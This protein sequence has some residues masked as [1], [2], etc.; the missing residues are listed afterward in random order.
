M[1]VRT[2]R[3]ATLSCPSDGVKS[4]L[5]P[6]LLQIWLAEATMAGFWSHEM[7]FGMAPKPCKMSRAAPV[8]EMICDADLFLIRMTI[9]MCTKRQVRR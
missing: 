4:S 1:K 7:T 8:A 3:S 2:L 5:T 6:C 9:H